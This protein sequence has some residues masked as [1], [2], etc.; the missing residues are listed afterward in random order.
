MLDLLLPPA[1]PSP[2]L[3]AGVGESLRATRAASLD[4]IQ[5]RA[6]ADS[7]ACAAALNHLAHSGQVIYDL[8]AGLYRWRQIMPVAI[9]EAEIGPE[10]AELTA[11]RTLVARGQVRCESQQE[12]P[13]G[14]ARRRQGRR[15][16]G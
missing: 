2:E 8:A 14:A 4:Q 12:A 13:R 9:G 6:V 3:I 5:V 15:Q 16:A 11:S 7:A 1:R 10:N